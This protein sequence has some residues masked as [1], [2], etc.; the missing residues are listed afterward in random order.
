MGKI[1]NK[2]LEEGILI[3]LKNIEDKNEE[4][5]RSYKENEERQ[6]QTI[7][8][9]S[10]DIGSLKRKPFKDELRHKRRKGIKEI[11]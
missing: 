10:E 1:F 8:N 3:K 6:L 4:Q 7:K 11:I 5:L 2:A 9:K